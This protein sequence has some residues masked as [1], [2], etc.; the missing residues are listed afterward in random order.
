M[1]TNKARICLFGRYPRIVKP[2]SWTL[3]CEAPSRIFVD[4]STEGIGAL[5]FEGDRPT[6]TGKI[7]SIPRSSHVLE[8][9]KQ[10]EDFFFSKANL[11]GLSEVVPCL[12]GTKITGMLL[13]YP[14]GHQEAV[15]QVRL[16]CLS[17]PLTIS[18]GTLWLG[19]DLEGHCLPY[20]AE[21]SNHP[22]QQSRSYIRV[23]CQGSLEWW[24]SG[25]QCRVFYQDQSSPVTGL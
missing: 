25:R 20:V 10:T 17:A 1:K 2:S 7:V 6:N 16:D 19:F 21:A 11:G 24:W 13:R 5:A 23:S 8:V 15:G 12:I 22:S 9:V 3:L 14:D 4:E 18:S